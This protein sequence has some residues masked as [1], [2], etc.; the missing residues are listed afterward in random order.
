LTDR[1]LFVTGAQRSGT[2]LLEKL[3]GA[4]DTVSMLSQPFPLLFAEVKRQFAGGNDP[5]PLGHLFLESRYEPGAFATFLRV[6]HT[7]AE[8]LAPLFASMVGFSGQY[9]RF[10]AEQCCGAFAGVRSEHDFADV[11]HVLARSLAQKD[12]AWFGSKETTCEEY[13]PPLLD[14][15]FRC[16][17]ILRDPRDLLTSLNYGRGREF[18]GEL[19]PTLFNVRSWRKSVAFALALEGHPRFVRCRYED[20]VTDPEGELG[21][22]AQALGLGTVMLPDEIRDADGQAWP[23]NSSH[24]EHRGIE[25]TSVGIHRGLLAPEVAAFVEA[26][27]LPELHRLGYP[28]TMKRADAVRV[29]ERFIDP[30]PIARSGMEGDGTTPANAALEI[31]RLQRASEPPDATS[32]RWF[33]FER[34]HEALRETFSP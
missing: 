26:T 22:V 23:G 2:T 24:A 34:S 28:T 15:G 19:K 27:C 11:V 1:A 25:R 29:I 32:Q 8:E 33:L 13:V 9:T 10:T 18:G 31:E 20:L 4:Q 14:R 30:Y 3:L 7:T 21:R 17:I 12:A 5:Y 16:A 6:W